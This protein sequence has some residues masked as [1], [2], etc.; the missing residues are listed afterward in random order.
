MVIFGMRPFGR[1]DRFGKYYVATTFWHL[2]WFPILPLRTEI[3]LRISEDAVD[4]KWSGIR[5]PFSLKSAV[6]GWVTSPLMFMAVVGP[7]LGTIALLAGEVELVLF[8]V[9][10]IL[11]VA[12][13]GLFVILKKTRGIGVAIEQRAAAL[14]KVLDDLVRA[15]EQLPVEDRRVT[16]IVNWEGIRGRLKGSGP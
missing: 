16:R 5:I 10:L 2:F 9:F 3:I 6:V 14:Q 4:T 8:S 13:A 11:A 7:L 15:E 1:V 12:S